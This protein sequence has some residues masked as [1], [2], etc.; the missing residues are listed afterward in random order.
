MSDQTMTV[1]QT[2]E[3]WAATDIPCSELN[4]G[5]TIQETWAAAKDRVLRDRAELWKELAQL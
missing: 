1:T 2:C 3:C 4:V 5:V